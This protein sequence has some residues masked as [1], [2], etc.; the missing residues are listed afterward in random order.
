MSDQPTLPKSLPLIF[1]GDSF[2]IYCLAEGEKVVRISYLERFPGNT[3]VAP[4]RESF[5]DLDQQTKAAVIAQVNR[6][7]MR[8]MVRV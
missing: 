2:F 4:T 3:Q 7:Y 6:R 5:A 8:R 1:D